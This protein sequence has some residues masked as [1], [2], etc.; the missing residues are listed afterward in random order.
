MEKPPKPKKT[1]EEDPL[2]LGHLFRLPGQE[3]LDLIPP[4]P[5]D[6]PKPLAPWTERKPKT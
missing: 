2:F 5:T 4:P 1:I 3:Q 6:G